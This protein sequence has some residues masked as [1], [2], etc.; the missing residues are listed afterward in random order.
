M[1]DKHPYVASSGPVIRVVDQLRKSFP[2]VVNA[3]TLKKLGIAPKNESYVLNVL[4]YIGVIDSEGEETEEAKAIFSCPDSEFAEGFAGLVRSGYK[5]LFDLQLDRA[6][7]LDVEKLIQFFRTSDQS[8]AIVGRRQAATFQTLAGI[9]GQGEV[10]S[11]RQ[12]RRA[13]PTP[14][15]KTK[16]ATKAVRRESASHEPP[17]QK[18]EH[19]IGLTVR[20][21]I[22]LPA[23]ADQETYDRI[24]RSIRENL[25]DAR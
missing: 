11:A 21:E 7:T 5:D 25:I 13:K 15:P 6:W 1:V 10:P 8:S 18:R 9:A 24:F 2:H 20:V 23:E 12:A 16:Q 22:N 3:E 19:D 4:R 17:T 14:G